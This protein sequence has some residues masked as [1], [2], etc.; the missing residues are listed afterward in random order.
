MEQTYEASKQVTPDTFEITA[1]EILL[2]RINGIETILL[3]EGYDAETVYDEEELPSVVVHDEEFPDMMF[4][5]A[6]AN[7]ETMDAFLLQLHT[8]VPE[9]NAAV[10]DR[11]IGQFEADMLFAQVAWDEEAGEVVFMAFQPEDAQ[12]SSAGALQVM[13][14]EMK[15]ALVLYAQAYEEAAREVIS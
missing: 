11:M 9:K 1:T 13:I 2:P 15:G 5:Y 14:E 12:L 3:E 7:P 8:V 4:S 6:E 10:V